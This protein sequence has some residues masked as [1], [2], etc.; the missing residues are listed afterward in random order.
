MWAHAVG[1]T[2]AV[3]SSIAFFLFVPYHPFSSLLIIA[4]NVLIIWALAAHG[5]AAERTRY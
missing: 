5:G 2:L 4:L 1:I 3:V